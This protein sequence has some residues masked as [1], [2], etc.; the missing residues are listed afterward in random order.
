[1]KKLVFSLLI[2]AGCTIQTAF[3]QLVVEDPALVAA[4]TSNWAESLEKTAT[5]IQTLNEQK[6]LLT[7]TVDMYTK[8]SNFI[9][10]GITVKNII[11]RQVNILAMVSDAFNFKKE[12]IADMDVYNNYLKNLDKIVKKSSQ[13]TDM[14]NT[15]M[16]TGGKMS[17]AERLK[18]LMDI[19]AKT[20]EIEYEIDERK[21]DFA[22]LNR[23]IKFL[24]SL[25][26]K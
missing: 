22:A 8:V 4:T 12:N 23:D 10:N 25:K 24:N 1:M 2:V 19:E 7:Q 9:K 3:S 17:D 18:F 26:M 20:E 13:L 5:Q 21:E 6:N 11:E 15:I 16:G 14:L